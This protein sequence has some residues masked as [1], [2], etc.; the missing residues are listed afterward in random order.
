VPA[1]ISADASIATAIT[2]GTFG[3]PA[4]WRRLTR[5]VN[6][7][8]IR[9]ANASGMRNAFPRKRIAVTRHAEIKGA[10]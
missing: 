6:R 2:A 8:A 1:P 4:A 10:R 9:I 7:K 5:G 3:N